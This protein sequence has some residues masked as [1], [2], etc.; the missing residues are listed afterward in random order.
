ML[1]IPSF[2]IYKIMN[3]QS[4]G[5]GKGLEHIYFHV[6]ALISMPGTRKLPETK[7]GV[8]LSFTLPT[9]DSGWV[10]YNLADE[11]AFL[12][13]NYLCSLFNLLCCNLIPMGIYQGVVH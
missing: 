12:K 10:F 8:A 11:K 3:F 2:K 9:A 5:N 6:G 7:L 4:W 13:I 1:F